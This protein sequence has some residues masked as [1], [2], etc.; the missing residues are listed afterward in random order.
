MKRMSFFLS[1]FLSMPAFA[2]TAPCGLYVVSTERLTRESFGEETNGKQYSNPLETAFITLE[3]LNS[4]TISNVNRSA[5]FAKGYSVVKREK[6]ARFVLSFGLAYS[7]SENSVTAVL[8]RANATI[9][10][11][12][13]GVTKDSQTQISTPELDAV[14]A[15][16]AELPSCASF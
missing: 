10:H 14:S 11:L 5:L 9:T 3:K 8:H 12:P 13:S 2:S 4:E 6:N 1:I 15:V 7:R 16:I